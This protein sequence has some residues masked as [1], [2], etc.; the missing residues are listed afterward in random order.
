MRPGM[1]LGEGA[2]RSG[3]AASRWWFPSA[4]LSLPLELPLGE[5]GQACHFLLLALAQA[6]NH[7]GDVRDVP[8]MRATARSAPA[9][10]MAQ[11]T[12]SVS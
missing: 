8:R 10:L 3:W 5:V 1:R 2:A 9:R 4:A 11:T 7:L 12:I 6:L